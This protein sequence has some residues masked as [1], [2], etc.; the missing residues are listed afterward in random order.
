MG[1]TTIISTLFILSLYIIANM[2]EDEKA[3]CDVIEAF[4]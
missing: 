4:L 2:N 1:D 3:K